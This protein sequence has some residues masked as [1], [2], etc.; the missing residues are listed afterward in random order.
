M[1]FYHLLHPLHPVHPLL[2]LLCCRPPWL[3]ETQDLLQTVGEALGRKLDVTLASGTP[4]S[5]R[6]APP[7]RT[8][9]PREVLHPALAHWRAWR[10]ILA[11]QW[12]DLSLVAHWRAWQANL[13]SHVAP[14]APGRSC[15][16]NPALSPTGAPP[17]VDNALSCIRRP[18]LY[19]CTVGTEQSFRRPHI[20]I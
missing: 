11:S 17:A 3:M 1:R 6:R 14:A 13:A 15:F 12:R 9:S 10:A 18:P 16:L 8:S 7:S 19:Y 20:A 5:L 4:A 2:P